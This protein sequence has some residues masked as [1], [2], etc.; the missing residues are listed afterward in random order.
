MAD[1]ASSFFKTN[2]DMMTSLLLLNIIYVLANF[3]DF[4]RPY[5]LRIFRFMST[6]REIWILQIN[7]TI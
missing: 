7:S 2:D 5:Y 4:I 3:L 6:M 1:P